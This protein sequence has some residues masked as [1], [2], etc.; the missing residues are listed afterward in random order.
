MEILTN[1]TIN[2]E[3]TVVYATVTSSIVI[4]VQ[5]STAVDVYRLAKPGCPG[6]RAHREVHPYFRVLETQQTVRGQQITND[7]VYNTRQYREQ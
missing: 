6:N 4:V 7:T 5:G 3:R 1:H 2:T